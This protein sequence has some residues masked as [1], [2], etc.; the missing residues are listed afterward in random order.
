[1]YKSETD[2]YIV[3]KYN[4][5]EFRY[6]VYNK[7]PI[8]STCAVQLTDDNKVKRRNKCYTCFRLMA[9][10]RNTLWKEANPTKTQEYSA[11]SHLRTTLCVCGKMYHDHHVK[12][13]MLSKYH[14]ANI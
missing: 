14:Q 8:C 2:F 5:K 12:R 11:K 1:M 3:P 13:H 4:I 6:T 10:T 9:N 7:M